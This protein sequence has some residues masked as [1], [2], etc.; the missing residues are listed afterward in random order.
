MVSLLSFERK[1]NLRK[2]EVTVPAQISH[3]PD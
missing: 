3:E 1:G 2:V